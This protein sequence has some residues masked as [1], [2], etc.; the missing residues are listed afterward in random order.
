MT[1][2]TETFLSSDQTIT[3]P[4]KGTFERSKLKSISG[5]V[6]K[7]VAAWTRT[8][9]KRGRGDNK[10]RRRGNYEVGAGGTNTA[11][12]ALLHRPVV[13]YRAMFHRPRQ[14]VLRLENA[15][16][17]SGRRASKMNPSLRYY[18]HIY[19]YISACDPDPFQ[20]GQENDVRGRPKGVSRPG[21]GS[22]VG[23][24]FTGDTPGKCPMNERWALGTRSLPPPLQPTEFES[25]SGVDPLPHAQI[26]IRLPCCCRS[27]YG[28]LLYLLASWQGEGRGLSFFWCHSN[29]ADEI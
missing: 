18:I 25:D 26:T 20:R 12:R 11:K 7:S 5:S 10:Y 8:R 13:L 1:I 19:I 4:K 15:E 24:G 17:S 28:S 21:G 23:V 3:F 27:G 6:A 16:D 2:S 9:G 29:L 22:R 14:D